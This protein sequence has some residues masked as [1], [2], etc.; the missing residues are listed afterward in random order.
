MNPGDLV[1]PDPFE[2]GG[3][4]GLWYHL[5]DSGACSQL[6]DSLEDADVALVIEVRERG[7]DKLC[8]VINSHGVIGWVCADY[9]RRVSP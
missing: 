7:Y 9:L 6:V 4:T 1:N 2:R 8:R 5:S 3:G